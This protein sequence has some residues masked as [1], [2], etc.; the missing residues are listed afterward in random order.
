MHQTHNMI[1]IICLFPIIS[2]HAHQTEQVLL[3]SGIG[4]KDRDNLNG[5]FKREKYGR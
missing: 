3:N 4:Q 1:T 2:Y 5:R